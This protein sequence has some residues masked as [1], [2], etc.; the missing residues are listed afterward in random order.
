MITWM[1]KFLKGLFSGIQKKQGRVQAYF[2]CPTLSD[3][4][5]GTITSRWHG[6]NPSRPT[7]DGDDWFYRRISP[8]EPGTHKKWTVPLGTMAIAIRDGTVSRASKISTG[9]RC[10]VEHDDGMRSGYFHFKRLVVLNGQRVKVGEPLGEIWASPK[11][12]GLPHLHFEVS[13]ID[14]YSPVDP[15]AYLMKHNAIHKEPEND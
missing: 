4:R 15:W 2:P 11:S 7:H 5:R 3:G 13:P 10:W 12:P 6:A 8:D 14:V 9:Y 1:I